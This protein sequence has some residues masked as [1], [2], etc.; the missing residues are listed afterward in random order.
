MQIYI[1]I[2]LHIFKIKYVC[3]HIHIKHDLFRNDQKSGEN[4]FDLQLVKEKAQQLRRQ[5]AVYNLEQSSLGFLSSGSAPRYFSYPSMCWRRLEGYW[6]SLWHPVQTASGWSWSTRLEPTKPVQIPGRLLPWCCL[7]FFA[8]SGHNCFGLVLSPPTPQGP[9]SHV[10]L[11]A[12]S[13][14]ANGTKTTCCW[15]QI[16][17]QSMVATKKSK[18]TPFQK[19]ICM[20]KLTFCHFVKILPFFAT[21][22]RTKN[23]QKRHLFIKEF[24]W[25]G[26]HVVLILPVF[27]RLL[28]K[29]FQI[30]GF[31]SPGSAKA[32][33]FLSFQ[34]CP[35]QHLYKTCQPQKGGLLG[36]MLCAASKSWTART[37][38]VHCQPLGSWFRLT[39]EPF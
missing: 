37:S 25:W 26:E 16:A 21:V 24:V 36:R 17:A 23:S 20:A 3:K 5:S 33:Q 13:M 11:F 7:F 35:F 38:N 34:H 1:C 18:K 28:D 31:Q 30:L 39:V 10:H 14:A 29:A 8:G 9:S 2:Y 4:F 32:S 19:R 12:S 6:K 27:P 15:S 22:P